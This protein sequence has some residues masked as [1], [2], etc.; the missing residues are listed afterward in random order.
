MAAFFNKGDKQN[1]WIAKAEQAYEK[2]LY[3]DAAELFTKAAEAEPS[4]ANLWIKLAASQKYTGKYEAA[5]RS[6]KKAVEANPDAGQAWIQLSILL[7]DSGRFEE[8]LKALSNAALPENEIRLHERK[9][10]W[11]ERLGRYAEAAETAKKLCS[12]N[13]SS[14]TYRVRL[15]DLL[16]RAGRYAEAKEIYDELLRSENKYAADAGLC[17]EL[18]GDTQ[19]ALFR[20]RQAEESDILA[21]Y[22]QARL[23]EA[24][25][26]FKE[27]AQSYAKIQQELASE[28]LSVSLRRA[29]SLMFSGNSKEAASLLEKLTA[30]FNSQPDLWYLLGAASFMNGSLKRAVEAFDTVIRIG[31]APA[32]IWYMKGTAEFLLG[33]YKEAVESFE[34]TGRMTGGASALKSS[35]FDEG[36]ILFNSQET[37]P[38]KVEFET[39]NTGLLSMQA[40]SLAAL[41]KYSEADK[42]ARLVLD[43][44]QSRSDMELLRLRCLAGQGKYRQANDAF[45]R[46]SAKNPDD[47]TIL[48]EHAEILMLAGEYHKA[49]ETWEKL[50]SLCPG[51]TL[52]YSR[53]TEAAIASGDYEGAK[54]AA[55]L[56]LAD[57]PHDLF[58]LLAA[59]DASYAAGAYSDSEKYYAEAASVQE[60]PAVLIGLGKAQLMLGKADE[61]KE[62][63]ALAGGAAG[64]RILEAK[65]AAEAGRTDEAV[66]LYMDILEKNPEIL[67]V[68]GEVARLAFSLGR[69]SDAADAVSFAVSKNDAGFSLLRLG[70]DACLY[71]D[72]I[73][74]AVSYYTMALEAEPENVSASAALAHVQI[75]RGEYREAL[76]LL[77]RAASASAKP[78][79]YYDKAV[80][81]INL[82]KLDEAEETLLILTEVDAENQAALLLLADVYDRK[83][84]YDSML[85]IYGRYL[86]LNT[87]NMEVFRKA[88]AVYRMRGET[89]AALNGYEMILERNPGDKLTLRFKAEAL[90][91][92][93]EF[94]E[95]AEVCASILEAGE[96]FGIRM[97]YAEALANAG[98]SESAQK[99][100]AAILKNN[101][102]LAG[103]FL[104]YADLL[105][106]NGDY[107]RADTAYARVISAAPKN[108][109]AY[110]ERAANAVKTGN[111]EAILSALRDSSAV[112]PKNPYV[113]A[114][115]A[116]L[117]AVSGHPTEALSFF[118]KAESAG[119]KDLDLYCS[120]A[121]IYLSQ[122]RFDMCDKAAS[123]ALKI[124][125]S[126][127][128]ALR[129]KAKAL[130][131][132]GR[133]EEAVSYYNLMLEEEVVDEDFPLPPIEEK[134]PEPKKTYSED[135]YGERR[136]KNSYR[137]MII[138]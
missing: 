79:Y 100:Y 14:K 83:G 48:F 101:G 68:A 45:A 122:S 78:E 41:G 134:K 1:Q 44:D 132:L 76:P 98:E 36:D 13:P 57:V 59:G 110:L 34:K 17:C 52:V 4:N 92:S 5:E 30:K 136:E 124:R 137:D 115:T 26:E 50:L 37:S 63:F 97:L 127:R 2:G 51:N 43:S 6:Y 23:E 82:G 119:C 138:N 112:N 81:E 58:S 85:E 22:R 91:A 102:D 96:D 128:T 88:S 35:M 90:F 18:T 53:L 33:K 80:C 125:P 7:G 29:F 99:E 87:E 28:D 15:A 49:A 71:S 21:R 39:A 65:S 24:A 67:G 95:A 75:L 20:Y 10:E 84:E 117:Y 70:G 60:N 120:R 16:L 74:E 19:S 9:C 121:F 118:D 66:S 55:D 94:K 77:K 46:V 54:R 72:R 104:S 109:R 89:E 11:L 25:G 131:G 111:Y 64:V 106:R 40:V 31:S 135:Y 62:S 133:F 32:S 69:F 42:A 108:E 47:Y 38:A 93:G 56:L 116:Y 107:A 61:A 129:L 73:D 114:G 130:E 126:N 86:E 123:E 3:E 8:A 105:S 12:A 27:A 103:A 113:L